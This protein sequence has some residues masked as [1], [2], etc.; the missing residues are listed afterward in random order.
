[1]KSCFKSSLWSW[2]LG[3][4]QILTNL[5][6]SVSVHQ[7]QS[8]AA[9]FSAGSFSAR[10]LVQLCSLPGWQCQVLISLRERVHN[11]VFSHWHF[12]GVVKTG[13]FWLSLSQL[14]QMDFSS[15]WNRIVKFWP[16]HDLSRKKIV[17]SKLSRLCGF[18]ISPHTSSYLPVTVHCQFFIFNMLQ[19]HQCAAE[20]L[21]G[22]GWGW[23]QDC[24][25]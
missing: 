17:V 2:S 13:I 21:L 23:R 14:A 12:T 11:G 5:T 10:I 20:H 22:P 19:E 4:A 8:E 15:Y 24:S 7:Q 9:W 25:P 3:T 16:A 6:D 18:S 1:M